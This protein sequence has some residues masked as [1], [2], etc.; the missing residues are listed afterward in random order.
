MYSYR[1]K[2]DIPDKTGLVGTDSTLSR[3]LTVSTG[4]GWSVLVLS[5]VCDRDREEQRE[6]K[7]IGWWMGLD[8]VFAIPG[9]DVDFDDRRGIE[10]C[11]W[12]RSA[13]GRIVPCQERCLGIHHR[14][15]LG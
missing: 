1:G 13:E 15:R 5:E 2:G 14:Q 6:G 4:A 9:M 3:S 8:V 10:K 7:C 11:E 12:T